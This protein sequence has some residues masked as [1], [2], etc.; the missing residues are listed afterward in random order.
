MGW[1]RINLKKKILNFFFCGKSSGSCN[2][3]LLVLYSYTTAP[4]N[5]VF[6]LIIPKLIHHS[7]QKILT[8][9]CIIYSMYYYPSVLNYTVQLPF[10]PFFGRYGGEF[11]NIF[12]SL[13]K[14]KS[15]FLHVKKTSWR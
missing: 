9:Y 5:Y 2:T 15:I 14:L 10:F 1:S 6:E 3:Q 13:K 11:L 12:F 4:K 7:N 8:K